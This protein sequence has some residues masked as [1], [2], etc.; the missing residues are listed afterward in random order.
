[1]LRDL[2]LA[3]MTEPT[4]KADTLSVLVGTGVESVSYRTVKRRL[5]L[6]AKI[7]VPVDSAL[8]CRAQAGVLACRPSGP[9]HMAGKL[10]S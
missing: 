10:H 2:L 8:L 9:L 1:M 5:R 4:S 3:K 7:I 6:I